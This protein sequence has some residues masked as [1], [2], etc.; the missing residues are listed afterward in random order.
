MSRIRYRPIR[1][2]LA[3]PQALVRAALT[4]IIQ[5]SADIELIGE[6]GDLPGLEARL[7][8][9]GEQ[10]QEGVALVSLQL[11]GRPPYPR[12]R[13]LVDRYPYYR[14]V[15]LCQDESIEEQ[16][17]ALAAGA[18]GLVGQDTHGKA[19]C[20]AIRSVGRGL[21]WLDAKLERYLS[22]RPIEAGPAGQ[23]STLT[24][25]ER[26]IAGLVARGESYRDIA[27]ELQI[28]SHTVKN[29]VR[30]IFGKLDVN[31]RVELAVIAV[32]NVD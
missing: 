10:L 26:Q 6:E 18:R 9:A 4:A 20:D 30:H 14:F 11:A 19:L 7:G 23:L 22:R 13:E 27:R 5:E 32:G 8:A 28:S 21:R 2:Q 1:L 25:R 15:A 16:S 17:E 31:S 3:H 29:H 24:P 12:L